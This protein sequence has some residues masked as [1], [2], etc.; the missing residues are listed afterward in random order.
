MDLPAAL[1]KVPP[2]QAWGENTVPF[3]D[4]EVASLYEEALVPASEITPA[5]LE[6]SM[7]QACGGAQLSSAAQEAEKQGP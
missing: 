1:G 5:R 6:S 7:P 2:H 3:A 4:G